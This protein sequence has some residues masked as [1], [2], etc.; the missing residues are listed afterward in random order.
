MCRRDCV[1]MAQSVPKVRG[2]VARAFVVRHLKAL[3]AVRQ[4]RAVSVSAS[5]PNPS[6]RGASA[7]SDGDRNLMAPW[8]TKRT[9]RRDPTSEAL[10]SAGTFGIADVGKTST[11]GRFPR[12]DTSASANPRHTPLSSEI[13]PR[14]PSGSTAR[15]G[16]SS[17]QDSCRRLASAAGLSSSSEP[18]KE[19]LIT[20]IG[21]MN[22]YPFPTTVSRKRGWQRYRLKLF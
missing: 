17:R 8:T 16:R 10:I 9:P 14:T 2:G 15:A 18:W 5:G 1:N 13:F 6:G 3:A 4:L 12:R 7:T 19:A 22:R 11:P 21:P 20:F